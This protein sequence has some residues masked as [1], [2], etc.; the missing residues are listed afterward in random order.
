MCAARAASASDAVS[1][2]A[3]RAWL[4]PGLGLGLGLG[5]GEGVGLGVGV[6]VRLGSAHGLCAA[7]NFAN[8]GSSSLT[9]IHS[10]ASLPPPTLG[11]RVSF[12]PSS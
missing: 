5:L 6:G 1:A 8:R 2:A 7:M 3:W 11:L 4:G 12:A 9:L 10:A